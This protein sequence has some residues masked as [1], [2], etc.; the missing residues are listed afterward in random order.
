MAP[1]GLL[2]LME[3]HGFASAIR[4]RCREQQ[5]DD[6][7]VMVAD[8]IDLAITCGA[9]PVQIEG[10]VDGMGLYFRARHGAWRIG[11]APTVDDAVMGVGA[12]YSADGDDD[13]E[14]WM[15]HAEAWRVVRES[16]AAWRTQQAVNEPRP[17]GV[18]MDGG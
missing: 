8:G 18:V 1:F 13:A 3:L 4:E 11:I 15:P 10:T 16:I 9:C 5:G 14:G 6:T 17:M 2:A 12:V 7:G